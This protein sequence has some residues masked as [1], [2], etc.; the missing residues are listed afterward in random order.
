MGRKA[1]ISS[2]RLLDAAE[3]V[4]LNE[5]PTRLTLD[6]VAARAAVSKG[7]LQYSFPSKEALVR[8]MLERMIARL[9]QSVA[10]A[11][12]T[13]PEGAG[14]AARAYVRG[15]LGEDAKAQPQHAAVLAAV[16]SDLALLA[17]QRDAYRAGIDRLVAEGLSPARA[18]TVMLATDGLW[19]LELLGIAPFDADERA[20][21]IAE[22]CD[23]ASAQR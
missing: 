9:E 11:H 7:G 1:S 2:D 21:I 22:L 10:A 3:A 8:G 14:R 12:D 20:A 15:T 13:E 19:L 5:G 18:A 17:P 23:L 16:A 6:S 4:V